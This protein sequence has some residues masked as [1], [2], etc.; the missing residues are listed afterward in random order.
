MNTSLLQHAGYDWRKEA[1]QQA[2]DKNQMEQAFAEQAYGFIANK[3]GV[4]M[5]DP[6]RLGFEIVY[7]NENNTRLC[8]IF[9][10]RANS[11]LLYAPAFFING[12]I[13]GTDLLYQHQ[14]KKFKPLTEEWV[15]FILEKDN[16]DVGS[17][18]SR[19]ISRNVPVRMY[20]NRIATPPGTKSGSA[21]DGITW[22]DVFNEMCHPGVSHEKM[23]HD[24]ITGHGGQPALTKLASMMEKCYPLAEA[25][26]NRLEEQDYLPSDLKLSETV[27]VASDETYI[28]ALRLCFGGPPA[29]W[30]QEKRASAYPSTVTKGYIF[31]DR[32]PEKVLSL[33]YEKSSEDMTSVGRP[34]IYDILMND[35]T[36]EKAIV[37]YRD[38]DG[39][40]SRDGCYPS[41]PY[42]CNPGTSF[43]L[44]I[45]HP[46]H[47]MNPS[48]EVPIYGKMHWD[49]T[50]KEATEGMT[51]DPASGK[52]Y[53]MLDG[54]TGRVSDPFWLVSK[55]KK[56]DLDHFEIL[57]EWSTRPIALVR[58]PDYAKSDLS[59]GLLGKA[60][61]F[62]EVKMKKSEHSGLSGDRVEYTLDQE[63]NYRLGTQKNVTGWALRTSGIPIKEASVIHH[64]SDDFSLRLDGVLS[65]RMS[66]VKAATIMAKNWKIQADDVETLLDK[67]GSHG[68]MDFLLEA[69]ETIKSAAA[70]QLMNEPEMQKHVDSEF[71]VMTQ[72]SQQFSVG[73]RNFV[74][75]PPAQ[76]IGDAWDPS[77]GGS[78]NESIDNDTLMSA[79]PEDIAELAQN[80]NIPNIFDHGVLGALLQTHD[81]VSAQDQFLPKLD[82]G[83]DA[84]GRCLFLYYAKPSDYEAAY[85]ADDMRNLENRLLSNFKTFGELVLELQ[86]RS[87]KRL[88][89][90]PIL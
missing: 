18:I 84:L 29:D 73:S 74:D 53:V 6:Y 71:G 21:D 80:K 3:A 77:M 56:N 5:R 45:G 79:S 33:V 68:H 42:S 85:G 1:S 69:A 12:E 9:A 76:R 15:T 65:F 66:R 13:K 37:G 44:L 88:N 14:F 43:T 82:D 7:R 20:L 62:I 51:Q 47:L 17:G 57:P 16:R 2:V 19:S 27:K 87:Q 75:Q 70:I 36:M 90:S 55:S 78:K 41:P 64:D 49:I 8:G 24:F 40:S 11:Q 4:L 39:F 67:A 48:P 54:A 25:I 58:N 10:F 83:L 26:V 34:G 30:P 60:V 35:G 52:G 89:S 72:P 28:P 61:Y 50:D 59:D 22:D 81:G 46:A 38:R 63:K 32:R 23:L 31:D 86:K